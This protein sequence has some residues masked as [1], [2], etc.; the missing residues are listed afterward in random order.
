M[1]DF[2]F[3]AL[4]NMQGLY[5]VWYLKV[6]AVITI[7][8]VSVFFLLLRRIRHSRQKNLSVQ[9]QTFQTETEQLSRELLLQK[10]QSA[11]DQQLVKLFVEYT[12]RFITTTPYADIQEILHHQW[13]TSQEVEDLIQLVYCDGKL[14]EALT[15]K[16]KNHF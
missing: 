14:S 1:A 16:I 8:G 2:S 6:I 5:I 10:L 15:H 13:F 7:F 9:Q 11:H 4:P 3:L 12:E